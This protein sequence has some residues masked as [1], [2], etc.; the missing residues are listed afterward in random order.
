MNTK[1]TTKQKQSLIKRIS[2][3]H[4]TAKSAYEKADVLF[5]R[6]MSG[7]EVGEVVDT[8]EGPMTLVD[9]F[10]TSNTAY[11]VARVARYE[12]KPVKAGKIKAAS[13]IERTPEPKVAVT[14]SGPAELELREAA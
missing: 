2:R 3:K 12:L 6:L 13:K 9:N 14:E 7:M 1:L 11:R 8:T 5:R 4:A 10:A